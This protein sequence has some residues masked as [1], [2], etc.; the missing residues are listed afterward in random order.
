MK[1][2]RFTQSNQ[3]GTIS[4]YHS[5]LYVPKR[6]LSRGVTWLKNRKCHARDYGSLK[7]PGEN[8]DRILERGAVSGVTSGGTN[9]ASCNGGGYRILSIPVPWV[10]QILIRRRI[11]LHRWSPALGQSGTLGVI[12]GAPD[13]IETINK[14]STNCG[15]KPVM[16]LLECFSILVGAVLH[17]KS[18]SLCL[19]LSHSVSLSLSVC[20]SVSLC[21][22]VCVCVS[23][24]L[25]VMICDMKYVKAMVGLGWGVIA[26]RNVLAIGFI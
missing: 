1:T 13:E 2:R 17:R 23:L 22:C 25:S 21:V 12:F 7:L 14:I 9:A 11:L 6:W 24:S 8:L 15:L 10:L 19:S 26:L 4:L 20:L 18:R 16:W 3:S 5:D